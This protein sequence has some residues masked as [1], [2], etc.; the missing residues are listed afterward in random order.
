M[1]VDGRCSLVEADDADP[2]VA[3]DQRHCVDEKPNGCTP[4]AVAYAAEMTRTAGI[5]GSIRKPVRGA[6]GLSRS[7]SRWKGRPMG[8]SPD[9]LAA[10][11]L[12]LLGPQADAPPAA[13]AAH[14]RQNGSSAPDSLSA[15][16]EKPQ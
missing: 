6:S 15:G 11:M 4:K 13:S 1:G 2:A 8:R 16:K 14:G 10:E 5:R 9:D 7:A 12:R 3:R